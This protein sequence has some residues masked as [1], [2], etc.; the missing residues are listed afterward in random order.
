MYENIE[1]KIEN[2]YYENNENIERKAENAHYEHFLLLTQCF[3]KSSAAE[4]IN[5]S[6]GIEELH[7]EYYQVTPNISV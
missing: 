6:S 4:H 1:E 5:S 2:A 7:F 3:P